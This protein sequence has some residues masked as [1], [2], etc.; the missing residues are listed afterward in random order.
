MLNCLLASY[1]LSCF[2]SCLPLLSCLP[3]LTYVSGLTG[4]VVSLSRQRLQK[5]D[6][7]EV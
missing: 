1:L 7:L 6:S 3:P 4:S 2:A 5:G